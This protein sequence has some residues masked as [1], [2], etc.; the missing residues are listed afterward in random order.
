MTGVQPYVILLDYDE[1]VTTDEEKE[2]Y[3]IE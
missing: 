1:E 3:T 2:D